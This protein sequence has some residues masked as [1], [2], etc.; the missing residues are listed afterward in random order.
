LNKFVVWI[1]YIIE[2]FDASEF[3]KEINRIQAFSNAEFVY[4]YIF[5]MLS[6]KII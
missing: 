1:L 2:F 4:F 5:E 3:S 6:A